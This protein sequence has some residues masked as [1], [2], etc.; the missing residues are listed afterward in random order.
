M[1]VGNTVSW[2]HTVSGNDRLLIVAVMFKNADNQTVSSVSYSGAR[3]TKVGHAANGPEVRSEIWLLTAHTTGTNTVTATFDTANTNSGMVGAS[4]SLTGVHQTTPVGALAS[5]ARATNAPTVTINSAPNELVIH[6]LAVRE[7]QSV[8]TGPGQTQQWN[9]N[10]SS[11]VTGFGSTER[12]AATVTM[13]AMMG[14]STEWAQIG[15]SIKPA[16]VLSP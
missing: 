2:S 13:S 16:A 7:S 1:S 9:V 5:A 6:A 3:L 14:V 8:T 11:D 12:G 15:V 10:D 4:I